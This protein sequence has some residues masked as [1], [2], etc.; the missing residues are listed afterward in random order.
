MANIGTDDTLTVNADDFRARCLELL[1][2]LE[3]GRLV[4]VVIRHD[5]V[6]AEITPPR[7][8]PLRLW[9]AMRGSVTIAPGVDLTEPVINGPL[10]AELGILHR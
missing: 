5:R 7:T 8:E 2:A 1:K 4:R 9:G 6:V 3:A 10:D